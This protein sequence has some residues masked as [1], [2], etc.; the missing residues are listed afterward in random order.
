MIC[1][2]IDEKELR[3][4]AA[5]VENIGVEYKTKTA[6]FKIM[7]AN[8]YNSK[9]LLHQMKQRVVYCK[10]FLRGYLRYES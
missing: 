2:R 6:A 4:Y 1:I 3:K 5:Y 9:L 10:Y 8:F 7:S